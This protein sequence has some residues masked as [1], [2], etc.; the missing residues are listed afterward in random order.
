MQ[1][2]EAAAPRQAHPGDEVE[3][4]VV[5]TAE[6]G[7]ETVK[8]VRY[9]IPV[10]APVGLMYLTVSD[11]SSANLFEFQGTLGTP[12]RS[13]AQVFSF[14]NGL[15]SN[16]SAYVRVW[17]ADASYTMDG[18]DLPNIPVSLAAILGRSQPGA[19][20]LASTHGTKITEIEVPAGDGVVT[21]SKT[22]QIEVKE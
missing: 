20:A 6:N 12:P 15:R 17:R 22:I 5:F 19:A 16:T 1:I 11:A 9:R 4:G 13:A 18:R 8:K 2:S 14:L 10:G 3:I 7:A 21:G